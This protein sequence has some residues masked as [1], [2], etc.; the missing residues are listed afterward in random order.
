MKEFKSIFG[1]LIILVGSFVLYKIV[2]AY[3]GDFRLG[4]LLEEQSMIYTYNG[5]S[6]QEIAMAI[7]QK[8]SDMDIPL[9]PEQVRVKR[10]FADLAITA[11]YTVHVDLPGYPLDLNFKTSTKNKDVM[12]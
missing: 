12:K 11:E 10:G 4:R 2:P 7:A 5:K 3:W 8:A 6:D 1:L 9:S